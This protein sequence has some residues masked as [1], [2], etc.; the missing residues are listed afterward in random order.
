MGYGTHVLTVCPLHA[1]VLNRCEE[2]ASCECLPN[3]C[4]S[5]GEMKNINSINFF[6]DSGVNSF[7]AT[8]AVHRPTRHPCHI[9]WP[10]SRR[11]SFISSKG[12]NYCVWLPD[13][14]SP[15]P[16]L[17]QVSIQS[18]SHR[19]VKTRFKYLFWFLYVPFCFFLASSTKSGRTG[20]DL[21]R[22]LLPKE[23]SRRALHLC[24]LSSIGRLLLKLNA[25]MQEKESVTKYS[26]CE[27]S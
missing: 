9:Y 14:L 2:H 16:S 13:A 4:L 15:L 23:S 19:R 11:V 6:C 8:P 27:C 12:T 24:Q 10:L 21:G 22:H 5:I 1:A 26:Q 18:S 25:E 20:K 17:T 3:N 7:V